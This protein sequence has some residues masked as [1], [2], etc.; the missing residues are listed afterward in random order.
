MYSGIILTQICSVLQ[1]THLKKIMTFCQK[2]V[3][4][5]GK[6]I[7]YL[8]IRVT[9]VKIFSDF[10]TSFRVPICFI[11]YVYNKNNMKN[12]IVFL[13]FIYLKRGELLVPKLY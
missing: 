2:S 1:L 3:S 4:Y 7:F 6:L 10:F 12:T 8:F 5:K 11:Q 13:V 9:R